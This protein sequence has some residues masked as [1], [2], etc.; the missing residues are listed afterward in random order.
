MTFLLIAAGLAW[1]MASAAAFA[2]SA[3]WL[4]GASDHPW[5]AAVATAAGSLA[6]MALAAA[7]LGEAFAWLARLA[8][9]R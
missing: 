1:M 7:S 2:A 4:M 8:I 9:V 3:V 6:A 5:P